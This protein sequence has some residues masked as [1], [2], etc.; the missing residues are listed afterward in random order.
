MRT[1]KRTAL[2]LWF[3][4]AFATWN[5]VFDRGV[6]LAGTEFTRDQILRYETGAPLASVDDTF[7]PRVRAAAL[8]ASAWGTAIFV[9]GALIIHIAKTSP[10]G[11]LPSLGGGRLRN[12]RNLRN[13]WIR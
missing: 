12:L 7:R 11:S 13:L 4:F 5:V 1:N 3:A 9:A 10:P 6:A 8:H 2:A